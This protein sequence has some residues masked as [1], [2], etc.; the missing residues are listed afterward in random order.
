MTGA[1]IHPEL[2]ALMAEIVGHQLSSVTF[3]QDYIQFAF[4]GPV[5]T[6]YTLPT[7]SVRS[8]DLKWA[9]AGYRDAICGEIAH[10]V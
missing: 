5:L 3:V 9:E 10:L 2:K 7:G 4:D 6:T 8:Q 1:T